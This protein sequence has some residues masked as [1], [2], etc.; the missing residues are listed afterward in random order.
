MWIRRDTT[1]SQDRDRF[2][3]CRRVLLKEN[4]GQELV[5]VAETCWER[6]RCGSLGRSARSWR[7]RSCDQGRTRLLALA[8][9][10]RPC[11]WVRARRAP[12]TASLRS[13]VRGP[14][15]WFDG[16]RRLRL[17]SSSW[18]RT[19]RRHRRISARHRRRVSRSRRRP[20]PLC[21]C[22]ARAPSR[23]EAVADSAVRCR[24]RDSPQRQLAAV[25]AGGRSMHRGPVI[26]W[27]G[28]SDGGD[29]A[30]LLSGPALGTLIVGPIQPGDA[31][32]WLGRCAAPRSHSS[33]G[34]L[35]VP[36]LHHGQVGGSAGPPAARRPA[37]GARTGTPAAAGLDGGRPPR[38][39]QALAVKDG[40]P[41]AAVVLERSSY[42]SPIDRLHLDPWLVGSGLPWP[43]LDNGQQERRGLG[44]L[45]SSAVVV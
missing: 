28:S 36:A 18:L 40:S 1:S 44:K 31:R 32:S 16:R 17:G 7:R 26:R 3:R 9:W 2:D 4:V 38:Q 45:E 11:R 6:R 41:T 35:G 30:G 20:M 24:R 33:S 23:D 25:V 42:V 27:S 34:A 39:L 22:P 10:T 21:R 19:S 15:D 13:W 37:S 12:S 5:G 43:R 8:R 29:P 14:S